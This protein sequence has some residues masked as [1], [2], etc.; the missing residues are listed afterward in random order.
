MNLLDY[1]TEEIAYNVFNLKYNEMIYDAIFE[2]LKDKSYNYIIKLSQQYY[3]DMTGYINQYSDEELDDDEV[4][5]DIINRF[6]EYIIQR[7]DSKIANKI[8]KRIFG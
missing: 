3:F 2:L 4:R 5:E 8:V 7:Y 1:V 6:S